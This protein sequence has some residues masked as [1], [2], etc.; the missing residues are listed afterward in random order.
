MKHKYPTHLQR[1]FPQAGAFVSADNP[2]ASLVPSIS[3]KS[4]H[5]AASAVISRHTIL[6]NKDQYLYKLSLYIHANTT[7]NHMRPHYHDSAIS[8]PICEVK[9]CQVWSVLAWGTSWEVQMLH[10]FFAFFLGHWFKYHNSTVRNKYHISALP[11]KMQ[12]KCKKNSQ[13]K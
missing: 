8:R 11:K 1:H 2:F 9:H 6:P 12:K 7:H 3:K 10:I 5:R 13:K 4:C